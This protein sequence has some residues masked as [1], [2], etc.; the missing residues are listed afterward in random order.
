M[1]IALCLP[2]PDPL[3][4]CTLEA[5]EATTKGMYRFLHAIY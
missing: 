5:Q 4:L 2:Q 3:A 1:Q